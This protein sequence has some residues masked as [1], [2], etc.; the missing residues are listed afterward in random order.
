M[1]FWNTNTTPILELNRRK[2][3]DMVVM[4][5]DGRSIPGEEDGP[6][7]EERSSVGITCWRS[8]IVIST[9]LIWVTIKGALF[10]QSILNGRPRLRA[11]P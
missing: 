6:S 3:A 10:Q 8:L 2:L 9:V 11:F 7:F 4:L 5:K 1:R